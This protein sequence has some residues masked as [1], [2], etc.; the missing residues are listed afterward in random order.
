[1]QNASTQSAILKDNGH[2]WLH[3]INTTTQNWMEAEAEEFESEWGEEQAEQEEA[4]Y[5]EGK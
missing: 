3:S 5:K 1:M 2:I 4:R